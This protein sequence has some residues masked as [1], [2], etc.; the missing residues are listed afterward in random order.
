MKTM[1]YLLQLAGAIFLV[2][3]LAGCGD[4]NAPGDGG[5]KLLWKKELPHSASDPIA[6]DDDRIYFGDNGRTFYMLRT[7]GALLKTFDMGN[8][9][10]FGVPQIDEELVAIGTTQAGTGGHRVAHLHVLNKI[11][12]EPLWEEL[13]AWQVNVAMDENRVYATTDGWAFAFDKSNGRQIWQRE[14]FGRNVFN[15]ALDGDRIYFATGAKHRRDGYLYCLEKSTGNLVFQDTLQYIKSQ[16][17]FGGSLSGVTV[18]KDF[19]YVPGDNRFLYCFN[20]HDGSLVWRFLADSPM[21]TPARISDGIV[22]TGSLNRT[23][24]AI[25]ALTGE[26]VWSF[27]NAASLRNNPPQFYKDYVLFN[28]TGGLYIF[29]KHTGERIINMSNGN[30]PFGFFS[31]AWAADGKIYATGYENLSQKDYLFACQF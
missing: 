29:E 22:Y 21:E 31:T 25:N 23:A 18:W 24:Y 11:T 6:L 13:F 8:G 28:S 20:K 2:S 26:L 7:D 27:M 4:L 19:V 30:G 15:P 5:M 3:N 9:A 14:T 12:L 17:Q 16:G 10:A 1:H